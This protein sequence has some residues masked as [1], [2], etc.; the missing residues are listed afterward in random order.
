MTPMYQQAK[1][2]LVPIY[3][4][5]ILPTRRPLVTLTYAQSL[6]SKIAHHG[7]QLLLS[8]KE[9]MAMTH[10]L[11]VM[12]D[13]I[14]VGSGTACIDDPQLNAR[15]VPPEDLIRQPQPIIID[16][17]L[18]LP[19]TCKLLKNYTSQQGKQPWILTLPGNTD[20]KDALEKAGAKI[21]VIQ[22]SIKGRLEWKDVLT[23]LY[24]QGVKRV[25]VEGGSRII[26]SCLTSG[27]VDQLVVT[28]APVYVGDQG[29]GVSTVASLDK[30]Q[31]QVF[32][33]DVVMAAKP[34]GDVFL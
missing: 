14:L 22:E 34:K 5:L 17:R 7:Q 3:N 1:D 21:F 23:L 13:A 16:T 33:R 4:N 11:R 8:G 28:I 30:V 10:R 15:Y 25:M 29:V 9:S 18:D 31:Y 26:Q 6:D 32:G 2:F 24:E 27:L 20:K 19:L 12:H